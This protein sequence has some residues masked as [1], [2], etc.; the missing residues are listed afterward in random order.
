M[1]W[2]DK[3]TYWH[4]TTHGFCTYYDVRHD[5]IMLKTPELSGA[6]KARLHFVQDQQGSGFITASSQGG[7]VFFGSLDN[8]GL[9]L[10]GLQNDGGRIGAVSYTHLRAHET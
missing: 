8:A 4:A 6:A 10:Y 7:E 3:A 2:G 9:A 1:S 5:V